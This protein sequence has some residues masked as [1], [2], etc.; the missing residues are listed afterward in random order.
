MG[1]QEEDTLR[2]RLWTGRQRVSK[3]TTMGSGA[4]NFSREKL[5]RRLPKL[6]GSRIIYLH[7]IDKKRV[8]MEREIV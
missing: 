8:V 1:I 5:K 6:L 2:V 7:I 3:S 4:L